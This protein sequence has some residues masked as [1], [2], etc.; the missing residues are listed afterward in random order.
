[1]NF[2]EAVNE[3]KKGNKIRRPEMEKNEYFD[4]YDETFTFNK[5]GFRHCGCS[6]PNFKDVHRT[7]WEIYEEP[8]QTLWDKQPNAPG[9][10]NFRT[11]DVKEAIKDFLTWIK[12]DESQIN[13]TNR[14]IN[15]AKEIF[16]ED[17]I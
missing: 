1:M 5:N 2:M 11:E 9:F 10:G 4:I 14:T 15:K 17:L 13:K 12:Q 7:D 6:F 16:G 8:K 3:M